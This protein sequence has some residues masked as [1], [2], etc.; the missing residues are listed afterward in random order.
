M[1]QD[2]ADGKRSALKTEDRIPY[3]KQTRVSGEIIS[4]RRKMIFVY[5]GVYGTMFGNV[6][7][8]DVCVY[9]MECGCLSMYVLGSGGKWGVC[10]CVCVW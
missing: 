5:L 2:T 6:C 10:A 1:K 8:Y 9:V 3:E 4:Q 7:V